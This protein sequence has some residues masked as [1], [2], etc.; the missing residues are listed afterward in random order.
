MVISTT[1]SNNIQSK[2]LCYIYK[3]IRLDTNVVFYIGKGTN[4][5]G[6]Y[7]RAYSSDRTNLH[8]HNIVK[9]YGYSVEIIVENLT[10]K[11]ANQKEVELI[12]DYGRIDLGTG[13]LVNMTAGGEGVSGVIMSEKTRK[14]IGDA[15]RGR[16]HTEQSRK[17]M[18]EA[19]K[20]HKPTEE[21]RNKMI[22]SRIKPVAQCLN[23]IVLNEY[24]SAKSTQEQGFRPSHV[25]ECCNGKRKTHGGFTWSFIEN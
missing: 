20:G 9:K 22:L 23:N 13:T 19:H 15:H 6:K 8:W 14:K 7:K 25:T 18:S 24:P 10:E 1:D 4:T 16:V 2:N 17:N 5:N 3:H 21:T 12:L 11:E